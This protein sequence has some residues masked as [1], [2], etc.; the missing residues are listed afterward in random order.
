MSSSTPAPR[1]LLDENVRVELDAFLTREGL[2]LRRLPK[3]APDR[4][5]CAVSREERLVIVTSDEDFASLP[6][7]KVHAVV[8]LR[9]P[10]RDAGALL[11]AF[12]RLV[13]ECRKWKGHLIVLEVSRWKAVRLPRGHAVRRAV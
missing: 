12:G 2:T 5:L 8:L 9:I 10:Q 4:S 7:G 1:F 6:A 13:A 11:A 3:G